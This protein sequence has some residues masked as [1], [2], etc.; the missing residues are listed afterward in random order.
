MGRT[1]A[2]NREA[3]MFQADN[4]A[5]VRAMTWV[6]EGFLR[7]LIIIISRQYQKILT[8]ANIYLYYYNATCVSQFHL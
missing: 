8:I 3:D 6:S 7:E 2:C 4:M 1:G 5:I